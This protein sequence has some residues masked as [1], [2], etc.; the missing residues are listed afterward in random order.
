MSNETNTDRPRLWVY[1]LDS[2]SK[3]LW[4]AGCR[5]AHAIG[6]RC[7]CKLTLSQ[8][9]TF[10]SDGLLFCR[11]IFRKVAQPFRSCPACRRC[12]RR[13][14]AQVNLGEPCQS[15]SAVGMKK[16]PT[17]PTVCRLLREAPSAIASGV[18][19]AM[20]AVGRQCVLAQ[21]GGSGWE[22]L[23]RVGACS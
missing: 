12:A 15:V 18:L 19:A 2:V 7:T 9:A 4:I 11:S 22:A 5:H 6:N 13:L 21:P 1:L 8:I 17:W 16:C 3:P 23:P 10:S 14:T 20:P